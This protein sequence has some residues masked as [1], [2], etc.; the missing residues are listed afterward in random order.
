MRRKE[1]FFG[2]NR[3]SDE[4][5]LAAFLRLFSKER[6]TSVL[7]P[8]MSDEEITQTIDLLTDIMRRHL[9]EKEYHELF[10]GEKDPHDMRQKD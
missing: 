3:T 5:S 6:L 10:L 4:K 9:E 1:I 8:K 7:I 2:M